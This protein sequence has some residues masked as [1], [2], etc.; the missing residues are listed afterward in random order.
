MQKGIAWGKDFTVGSPDAG[1][2]KK[3][4]LMHLPA[5][6]H[7]TDADQRAVELDFKAKGNKLDV[8]SSAER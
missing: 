8:E 6:T 4:V 3:V 5:A 2:V 1:N 7:I